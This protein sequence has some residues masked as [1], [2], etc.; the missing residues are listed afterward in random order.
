MKRLYKLFIVV[1]VF[2]VSSCGL[3]ELDLL[4]NPNAVTPEN[5]EVGLFFNAIQLNFKDF[6][7]NAQDLTMPVVR[8]RAMT[9]G[10]SYNNAY[11]PTTF[12]FLWNR[13]YADLLPDIDQLIE[14]AETPGNEVPLFAGAGRIFKAYILMTLVDLFGDIPF[15][16]AGQGTEEPSPGADSQE[17]VYE[18]ALGLI[19][20]A[21]SN[22]NTPGPNVGSADI[23]YGGNAS[24]WL[25]FANSMRLKYHL[26]TRLVGSGGQR[27]IDNVINNLISS[28]GDDFQFQYGTNRVIPDSRHPYY[29]VHY[30]N[31]AAGYL[32]NFF[33]W[34][35]AGEKDVVDPRLNYYFYRQDLNPELADAFTLDCVTIPRPLHYNGPFPWCFVEDGGWWGRDHGNNDGIPPDTERRSVYGLYPAGGKF[36]NG[37]G[38]EVQ[39]SGTDG[40]GGAG[41]APIMLSSFVNFMLAE[42]ALTMGV[43]GDP[44]TYLE[45]GVRQSIAKVMSFGALDAGADASRFPS[46]DRVESYVAY[47]LDAYDSAGSDNDRLDV[48]MKEYHIAAWGN[49]LEMYN[50]YRRTGL[51]SGMQ[52]TRDPNA[53]DFPRLM[54]YPADY[55][56]LNAKASQRA[57]TEQV[58]WDTNP[59]GFIK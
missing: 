30:E 56:N 55:V 38:G 48:V 44:R 42:A 2:V 35:L 51:P 3:T 53:G 7:H 31:G 37:T 33:M 11:A 15:S 28:S 57:I 50:A 9:G 16:Q 14:I 25:K 6:Y 58:F 13:A 23:Y 46:A 10:N 29:S 39:N 54:F 24:K 32:S 43:Q 8:M 45:N 12:N 59:A 1:T 40:A 20:A 18:A 5:A 19:D 22:F 49:G 26:T 17:S 41:I 27:A 4:D 21:A 34:Q 47:V 36:D 52:P